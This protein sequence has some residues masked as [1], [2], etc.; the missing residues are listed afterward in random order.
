MKNYECL[1]TVNIYSKHIKL[2]YTHMIFCA[3]E[4]TFIYPEAD[5]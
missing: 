3:G 5:S 2:V 1:P 4:P